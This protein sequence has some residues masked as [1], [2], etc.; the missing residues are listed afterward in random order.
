MVNKASAVPGGELSGEKFWF[1]DTVAGVTRGNMWTLMYSAFSTIGLLTF[2]SAATTFVLTANLGIPVS[3]QGT[4][5]G[6]LVFVTEVVQI[7]IFG[8]V[9]VMSDRVGRR[10]ILAMGMLGMGTAYLL[11]PFAENIT[12]LTVYRAIYALGLGSATGMLGT[13][14][15]DYPQEHCRGR[16]VALT[17]VLN[18][19]GVITVVVVLGNLPDMLVNSGFEQISAGRITS[20][21]AFGAC[22][23]SAV[24]AMLG[25]K[26]GTPAAKTERP[27]TWAL[28]KSGI[29]EARN[30]RIA[31][32]YAA[33]FVARSDLVILGTFT[34]LWGNLAATEAGLE[35]AEALSS[36]I[37]LFAT[38]SA[39][40][41]IWLP[42]L[43]YLVDRL[44]RVTSLA[45]CMFLMGM[46]FC[47]MALVGDPLALSSIQLFL[48][49]GVGQISAFLGAQTLVG[50]EAPRLQRGAVIGVFN[51]S[52]AIGILIMSLIGGRLFDSMSPAAP[53]VLVGLLGF[54]VAALAVV[55]RFKSPGGYAP[56]KK[57]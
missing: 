14:V 10:Q 38:T 25:L 17:G 9:G 56:P 6:D 57:K 42:I 22:A 30:P 48:F 50:T 34:V 12:E 27:S 47:S 53:F 19:I 37:R 31:L 40:A 15:A 41:L 54:V 46:G 13:I 36:G 23:F 21:V 2:I 51:K 5:S 28:I 11:Y 39:A 52:G 43:G 1:I 29:V 7:L 55:V 35:P 49:L 33:A 24:I 3:E 26:K 16:M 8:A 45:V 20:A 4:I 32:S 18:G 44:N